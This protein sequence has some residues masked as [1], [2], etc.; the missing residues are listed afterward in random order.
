LKKVISTSER[1]KKLSPTA[2]LRI[3]GGRSKALKICLKQGAESRDCE[4][5]RAEETAIRL[6]EWIPAQQAN[7]T[8]VARI[9]EGL[10]E[11]PLIKWQKSYHE[12]VQ[13]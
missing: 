13:D 11:L 10:M 12:S 9:D 3:N 1:T 5:R 7:D 6:H 4:T 2:D 8:N